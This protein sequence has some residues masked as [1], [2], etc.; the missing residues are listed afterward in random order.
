LF[1]KGR[2]CDNGKLLIGGPSRNG[3]DPFFNER[4]R[5]YMSR[6]EPGPR[7]EA[8]E[9]LK[10]EVREYY[11]GNCVI[12]G[13]RAGLEVHHVNEDPSDTIFANLVPIARGYNSGIRLNQLVDDLDPPQLC[14]IARQAFVRDY[15]RRSYAC[16]RI[17]ADLF[18]DHLNKWE[19]AAEALV[20]ALAQLRREGRPDLLLD[21]AAC[22]AGLIKPHNA[23][24]EAWYW[25]A[26]FISQ[27][28][29]VM[30]D[31]MDLRAALDLADLTLLLS[32]KKL[33]PT[34][35]SEYQQR[36]A[37]MNKRFVLASTP[38]AQSA[39]QRNTANLISR[40]EEAVAAAK[41]DP[42]ARLSAQFTHATLLRAAGRTNSA[43]DTA[44]ESI[45]NK[46]GGDIW[47]VIGLHMELALGFIQSQDKAKAEFH[48]KEATDLAITHKI[49]FIPVP[50]AG[51]L[52][53]PLPI[54]AKANLYL[55]RPEKFTRG[56]NPFSASAIS[57]IVAALPDVR[58]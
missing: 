46:S 42:Q 37:R 21:T 2:L 44:L 18:L 29:L 53:D 26:E 3:W 22:F 14:N 35:R 20:F 28:S 1:L 40:I 6:P 13:E 30:Y 49:K 15:H 52:V 33:A 19:N 31:H 55:P 41:Y 51:D 12:S 50:V 48:L 10:T 7:Q 47:T 54:L 43:I 17:V 4:L 8:G 24:P 34:H 36:L 32:E 38:T 57:S 58:K 25:S 56:P 45:R 23:K 11:G 16:N 5:R 9:Q 39:R 27:L